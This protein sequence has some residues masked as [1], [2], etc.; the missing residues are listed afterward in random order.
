MQYYC[1]GLTDLSNT[2]NHSYCNK[3]GSEQPVI[4]ISLLVNE[5]LSSA[6]TSDDFYGM[7]KTEQ[8]LDCYKIRAINYGLSIRQVSLTTE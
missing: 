6:C 7:R 4:R 2:A 8:N 5:D 3:G 1:S